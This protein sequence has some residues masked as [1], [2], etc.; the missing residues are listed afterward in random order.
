MRTA[1]INASSAKWQAQLIVGPCELRG[2]SA[3]RFFCPKHIL[4]SVYN[5]AINRIF[6][7]SVY[8]T[9]AKQ[10]A[11]CGVLKV[12]YT[13][14]SMSNGR[15]PESYI[16]LRSPITTL[17]FISVRICC[18]IFWRCKVKSRYVK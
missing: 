9:D 11:N 4:R 5:K 13:V 1:T 3:N 18:I 8:N 15:P 7:S 12:V 10:R 6:T 17:V 16:T 2:V 14:K